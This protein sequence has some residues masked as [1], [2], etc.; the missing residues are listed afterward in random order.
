MKI[1]FNNDIAQASADLSIYLLDDVQES[2]ATGR[3]L[4]EQSDGSRFLHLRTLSIARDS[5]N[6]F[7][8]KSSQKME[9]MSSITL[10][11]SYTSFGA[12]CASLCYSRWEPVT[13]A[14]ASTN[15]P[16]K[17]F[18]STIPSQRLLEMFNS[19]HTKPTSNVGSRKPDET[20]LPP[21]AVVIKNSS[22]SGSDAGP[23]T[24]TRPSLPPMSEVSPSPP[25]RQPMRRVQS[26][27]SLG[28]SQAAFGASNG[29]LL[30]AHNESLSI[31]ELD[32]D[33]SS[34]VPSSSTTRLHSKAVLPGKQCFK[35]AILFDSYLFAIT[36]KSPLEH[37]MQ[38]SQQSLAVVSCCLQT[39]N[40]S[41]RWANPTI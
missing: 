17:R 34:A 29:S 39:W 9:S 2:K 32:D 31:V 28:A 13:K 15:S 24:T 41:P 40:P 3:I 8:D 36:R 37:L 6:N 27:K 19:E 12:S 26:E 7:H 38:H 1:V 4:Q 11:G 35:K 33:E 5:S 22:M 18:L 23:T 25:R 20:A 16:T 30:S 10:G 21:G 14:F